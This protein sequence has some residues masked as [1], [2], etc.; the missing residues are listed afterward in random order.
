[1]PTRREQLLDAAVNLLGSKGVRALTHRAVDAAASMP[2]GSTANY[3][4]TRDELIKGVVE[5]FAERDRAAW[6]TVVRLVRPSNL[7]ELAV[8]LVGYVERA[9]GPERA[10]T[11][12]RF[13]IMVE[14]AVHPHLGVIQARVAEEIRGWATQWLQEVGSASPHIDSVAILDYLDGLII[15]CLTHPRSSDDLQAAMHRTLHRLCSTPK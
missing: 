3:F 14:A 9:L 10:M 7:D 13:G 6:E 12:A 4:N 5:R 15:H 2:V 1:M 11:V 8:A